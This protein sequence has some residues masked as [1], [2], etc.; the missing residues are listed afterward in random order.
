MDRKD[1]RLDG[2]VAI[3]TGAAQGIGRAYALALAGAGARVC[4]SDVTEPTE[5]LAL[6]REL[7]GEAIGVVANITD[8]PSLELS[9]AWT[10][11]STTQRFLETFGCG[12]SPKS[13]MKSGTK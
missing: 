6:I 8:Q 13:A 4:V 12:R 2:R 5:T 9:A 11:S 3:V 7:H 10:C 1:H